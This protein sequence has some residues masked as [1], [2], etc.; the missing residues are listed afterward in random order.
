MKERHYTFLNTIYYA[1]FDKGVYRDVAKNWR[2]MASGYLLII[3]TISWLPVLMGL[4][5][6]AVYFKH[7]ENYPKLVAQIPHMVIK[8]GSMKINKASPHFIQD[9]EQHKFVVFDTNGVPDDI[10]KHRC[11]LLLTKTKVVVILPQ[12]PKII[13]M[14]SIGD[15]DVDHKTFD[16]WINR[17]LYW[18]VNLA[19]P[20]IVLGSLLYR[21]AQA[22]A[23]G[24]FTWI[25]NLILRTKLGFMTCIRLSSVAM[26]PVIC[27]SMIEYYDP[28]LTYRNGLVLMLI[29]MGFAIFAVHAN[30][31]GS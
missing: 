1:W 12:G 30:K 31:K 24:I 11:L 14:S 16:T 3:L 10:L 6:F 26:T 18:V 23:L 2:G 20:L 4:I 25:V 9:D 15:W 7:S 13:E 22:I 17:S 21:I 27:F 5:I 28:A 19:F 8:D 29:N